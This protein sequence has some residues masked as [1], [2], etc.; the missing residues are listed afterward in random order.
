[1]TEYRTFSSCIGDS[2][3]PEDIG[4]HF[5]YVSS[6]RAYRKRLTSGARGAAW[7][8][9]STRVLSKS[10]ITDQLRLERI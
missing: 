4:T 6:F 7:L 1:M 10:Q 8:F 5:R 3:V 9:L 2:A